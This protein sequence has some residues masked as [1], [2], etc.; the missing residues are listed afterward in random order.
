MC[1]AVTA[2]ARASAV[3]WSLDF[4]TTSRH[5]SILV[6]YFS[7]SPNPG[8][9]RP[10]GGAPGRPDPGT[11]SPGGLP[12]VHTHSESRV[13]SRGFPTPPLG[14]PGS[15]HY[16]IRAE[17]SVRALALIQV[18]SASGYGLWPCACHVGC[19]HKHTEVPFSSIE[20]V[21][22]AAVGLTSNSDS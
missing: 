13:S 16:S 20:L 4:S 18:L 9:H 3:L 19:M 11:H 7:I 5:F 17:K 10:Q 22:C 2:A 14:L 12:G 6:D 21:L 1:D 15:G 8:T